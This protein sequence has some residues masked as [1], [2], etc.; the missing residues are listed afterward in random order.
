MKVGFKRHEEMSRNLDKSINKNS[1]G[2]VYTLLTYSSHAGAVG[3]AH[4][5]M[6][7]D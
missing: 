6:L 4:V 1:D 5:F 7:K 2:F 3:A